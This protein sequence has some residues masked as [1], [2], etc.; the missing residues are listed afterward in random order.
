MPDGGTASHVTWEGG[1]DATPAGVVPCGVT[2]QVDTYPSQAVLDQLAADG[3]LYEGEDSSVVMSWRFVY[4]GDCPVVQAPNPHANII[5]TCGVATPWVSNDLGDAQERL[6]ASFVVYVD[7]VFN[8]AL[9]AAGG[10]VNSGT[11]IT[12]P[13]DSGD[14]TVTVRTG[15]AFGD[16]LLAT[17][18]VTSDCQA[19]ILNDAAAALTYGQPTCDKDG[20][21]SVDEDALE[22]ASLQGKLDSTVGDHTATFVADEGHAFADG[23]STL[24]I[25][26]TVKAKTGDCPVTTPTPTPAPGQVAGPAPTDSP[27]AF[28]TASDDGSLADTGSTISAAGPI[29]LA[30]LCL[31][32]GVIALAGGAEARR[33]RAQKAGR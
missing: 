30:G 23:E 2:A 10:E 31:A 28:V 8:Q 22:N 18:T 3:K 7:G 11:A 13:E 15:P 4:G 1:Q 16:E 6:T 27:V 21:V 17:A 25:D 33:R 14:H 32:F 26:Y 20:T 9:T 19:N 29:F 24:E 5:V 12:F